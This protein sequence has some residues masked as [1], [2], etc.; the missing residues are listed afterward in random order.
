[1]AFQPGQSG[2]P[3]GRAKADPRL[4]ALAREQTERAIGVILECLEDSDKRVALKA[5]E[6]LLDRGWGRP[7]QT[8]GGDP[9]GEP[10]KHE[11]GW[12]QST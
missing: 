7:H 8:V 4:K 2:N 6:L 1:M 11:F 9:S 12:K 3:G 10:I 5:A